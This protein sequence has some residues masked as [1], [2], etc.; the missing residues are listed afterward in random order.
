MPFDGLHGPNHSRDPNSIMAA[1]EN[2]NQDAWWWPRY[3]ACRQY[4][5]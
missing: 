5:R 4:K 2:R 1:S 3:P